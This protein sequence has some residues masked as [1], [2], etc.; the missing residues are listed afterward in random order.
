M[1]YTY[2]YPRPA[3]TVDIILMRNACEKPEVL[4]IQRLDPPFQ[5]CWAF[6]G[7]F[8]DMEETLEEAATRELFEE[9]GVTGVLLSQFNAYSSLD[10]DPRGRTISV[11]FTGIAKENETVK[12]G[13]DAKD[14]RWFKLEDLPE[15]AFDHNEIITDLITTM[16]MK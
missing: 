4:L 12:A 10:R 3:V 14:T 15:L 13:D 11:I 1:S 2:K 8:V 5:D 6:P 7:G 9:T 16:K